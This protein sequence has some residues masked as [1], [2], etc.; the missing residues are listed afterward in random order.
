MQAPTS[1]RDP[2][3]DMDIPG[4]SVLEGDDRSSSLSDID[5]GQD[6]EDVVGQEPTLNKALEEDSEA[7]T[8]RL[9]D[10][11]HKRR[12]QTNVVLSVDKHKIELTNK[13]RESDNFDVPE[14]IEETG[15][16]GAITGNNVGHSRSQK[17]TEELDS[18]LAAFIRRPELGD[19]APSSPLENVGKKRKRTS[20]QHL[21]IA[22]E[23]AAADG[24]G[25][26][27]TLVKIEPRDI[28]SGMQNGLSDQDT[29][30]DHREI[31]A[32]ATDNELGRP[33]DNES[34]SAD[35]VGKV[36]SKSKKGKTGKRKGKKIRDEGQTDAPRPLPLPL[37]LPPA[38]DGY[39][40]DD[41]QALIVENADDAEEIAPMEVDA[42]D[43][44]AESHTRTEE[45]CMC[46]SPVKIILKLRGS[47][48]ELTNV[49]AQ[50]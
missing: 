30:E 14:G 12:E 25:K 13:A 40:V 48:V 31:D 46:R 20:P 10:S 28:G 8:E 18:S 23:D 33:N 15:L 1:G 32:V 47:I 41:G 34:A 5:D 16:V 22:G 42:D 44:E 21:E 4:S 3:N 29:G 38:D 7:E 9:D 37:P 50:S 43:A 45:E 2:I 35:R 26:R 36:S 19:R 39:G 49:I 24:A 11:P 6:Q 27:D 17:G